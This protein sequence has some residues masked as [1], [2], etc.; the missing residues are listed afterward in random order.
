[1]TKYRMFIKAYMYPQDKTYN[2]NESFAIHIPEHIMYDTKQEAVDSKTRWDYS[3]G[4]NDKDVVILIRHITVVDGTYG[5]V[6]NMPEFCYNYDTFIKLGGWIEYITR[7]ENVVNIDRFNK[8]FNDLY[9]SLLDDNKTEIHIEPI[10][11]NIY[12]C[13]EIKNMRIPTP[14]SHIIQNSYVPVGN[15]NCNRP[16]V[17][18]S[19]YK[20]LTAFEPNDIKGKNCHI[21]EDYISVNDFDNEN[22]ESILYDTR[23]QRVV[24]ESE[25]SE[26]CYEYTV[27]QKRE[28]KRA[29]EKQG[30]LDAYN[31]LEMYLQSHNSIKKID[32]DASKDW[33]APYEIIE[34]DLTYGYKL[35][36]FVILEDAVVW[37]ITT[38]ERPIKQNDCIRGMDTCYLMFKD[39]ITVEAAR[40]ID[41]KLMCDR[42]SLSESDYETYSN[43]YMDIS[44]IPLGCSK[45]KAGDTNA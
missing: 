30:L 44:D 18:E 35:N 11:M 32:C 31:S 21:T 5:E 22:S 17:A 28:R 45:E 8:N 24:D 16:L 20:A 3:F 39:G 19:F 38:Y 10:D 43:E 25:W 36:G 6:R 41:Y 1:M 9:P 33:P 34:R 29:L 12:E 42:N 7:D 4:L 27:E 23:M 14:I 15:N 2:A 26:Y 37:E 40:Q 13:Q